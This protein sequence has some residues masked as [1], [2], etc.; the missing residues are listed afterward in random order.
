MA[1][2][3]PIPLEP[4]HELTSASS[5]LIDSPPTKEQ[6]RAYLPKDE[7]P[8]KRL[9]EDRQPASEFGLPLS[10]ANL[11]K[12]NSLE[13]SQPS[14][15][16]TSERGARKRPLSRQS[17]VVD[18]SQ[19][20]KSVQSQTSNTAARYR[21]A[22]TK[23]SIFVRHGPL[24]KEIRPRIDAIVQRTV[25]EER[26]RELHGIANNLCY[27]FI[28]VLETAGREDDSV[29]PIH[30]A[31]SAMDSGEKF[32]FPRKAGIVT[33]YQTSVHMVVLTLS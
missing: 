28:R 31:L 9:R 5:N 22:L 8:T 26:K 6:K 10:I 15:P 3:H 4:H 18:M 16:S 29:E 14:A 17:S 13:A 33:L 7:R 1:A 25:S 32:G 30:A 23:V 11:E 19:E 2:D 27:N 12:H 24:P 21:L 20:R